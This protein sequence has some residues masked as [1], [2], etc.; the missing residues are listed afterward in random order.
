MYEFI[1]THCIYFIVEAVTDFTNRISAVV[2]RR[3][4]PL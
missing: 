4:P 3:F 2:F 1:T